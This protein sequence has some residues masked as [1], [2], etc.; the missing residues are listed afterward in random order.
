MFEGLKLAR[1]YDVVV[2]FVL[3]RTDAVE[4][5]AAIRQVLASP[6][7]DAHVIV[8]DNSE[9][10]VALPCYDPDRVSVVASGCNL[11]YG[12]AHNLAFAMSAGCTRYNFV[13]NTDLRFAP[14]VIPSLVSY[15]DA[16]SDVG[17]AMPRVTYPDG[18]VQ[19]LCRLLP[20]PML[21]FARRFLSGSRYVRDRNRWYEFH[22]WTY[23]RE[24]SFPFLS[25]CFM[26][27]R[28]SVLDRVGGFDC[29]YFLYAEDLDLSRRI[30]AVAQTM[31]VPVATVEHGYRTQQ[32]RSWRLTRYA[33]VSLARY[34]FKWGWFF[35]KERDRVNRA[36]IERLRQSNAIA[37]EPCI[38]KASG[39]GA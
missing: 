18:R 6:N 12:R 25:G 3:Y 23:D 10:P 7:L 4:T 32:F 30:H 38:A 36:C 11:G 21:L 14:D 39:V 1:T 27:I 24:A 17:L 5:D 33:V 9:V 8:V 26:A 15:L 20:D 34:F 22:D 29:R 35:D 31:F 16:H 2:S 28:R 37:A 19:Q 13:L